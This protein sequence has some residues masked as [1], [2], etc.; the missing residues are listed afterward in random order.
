MQRHPFLVGAV[1][2]IRCIGHTCCSSKELVFK[3]N[4][5]EDNEV[6]ANQYRLASTHQQQEQHVAHHYTHTF[7]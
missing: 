7:A 4:V 2:H 5:E 3:G 6:L 1:N